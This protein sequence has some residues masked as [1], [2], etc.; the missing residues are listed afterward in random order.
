MKKRCLINSYVIAVILFSIF[1]NNH[2]TAQN[3]F[4]NYITITNGEFR[5]GESVFKPLFINYIVDIACYS[6]N[7]PNK[8]YFIA[9]HF[10]YSETIQCFEP[11]EINGE[12]YDCHFGFA[13]N[14]T[15][16]IDSIN[17]KLNH[18]LEVMD[19]L[20]FN[21]V[22]IAP[23]VRWKNHILQIPT[24]SYSK[25]FELMDTLIEKCAQHNLR[26]ILVLDADTD[27]FRQFDQYCV[28]LDS[29]SRHFSTN[30]TVMA[31][32]AY[33]E[34]GFKW[35]NHHEKD[36]IMISNWSRKWYYIIKKNA[37]NQLVTFGLDGLGNVL[38]WDPS[39]LTYDF[40][41]MHFYHASS[42]ADS[43]KMAVSCY[44]K[45]MNDNVQDV[46]VLGETGYSGTNSGDIC[47]QSLSSQTG[48]ERDQYHYA[49]HTMQ[50][51]LECGCKGYS[52]WQYQDV[53]WGNC[54]QNYLGLVTYYP[55]N[56]LKMAHSLFPTY[57]FR[58]VG[59][60]CD[61]PSRYYNIPG[62]SYN[63][64][65]GVVRDNH[66]NP[67]KDAVVF[68]WSRPSYKTQYTTFTDNQG[69]YT[70]MTPQDTIIGL[71]WISHK[72]YTSATVDLTR[73]AP[74]T[75][76]LTQINYN[77]WKKNWTNIYY[78]ETGDIPIIGGSDAVVV[79]NFCDDEA[80]EL[81][82]VK[83]SSNTAILYK[84]NTN[85]WE[86]MCS[87]AIGNWQISSGD[88]FYV[89]DFNGD[90]YDELLCVQNISNALAKIFRYN[91]QNLNYPWQ[92]LW[93]NSGNGNIG[94]WNYAPGDVILPGHFT[95][96]SFC[97][98]ICI[99]NSGRQ[100]GA[101]CQRL[102]S[103]SWTTLWT[104]TTGIG[105]TYIGPW[106]LD[107]H[108][109]YYVGDFSGDGIDELFCV[110]ATQGSSDKMTLMQYNSSWSSL[111]SN[112][113]ISQGVDIYPYR[114]NLH[115]GNY[116]PD[117]ADE[118][119]GVGTEAAKFDLNASNQW[120]KSWS[121]DGTGR[122]SDWSVNPNHRIFFMKTMSLVPD[123]LFV[124]RIVDNHYHCDG[125]S[126]DP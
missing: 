14:R 66:S 102:D 28:Y 6:P 83:S 95:S 67:I 27:A 12:N 51:A 104:A 94:N 58:T 78:P 65:Q 13:N 56:N 15:D 10:N 52:W 116:D 77:R 97:S 103:G 99:R 37:P 11:M 41:S 23:T 111:W 70:I 54:L 109:K 9:P 22:R 113:G 25:Y 21:V 47:T 110:Q 31:Y 43:S 39:A 36:K 71:V 60:P 48:T 98:L 26:V 114:A 32:V 2:L 81:L 79:G 108:D 17:L 82:I 34:P 50:K 91:P 76:H 96:T 42:D 105:G 40:L 63:N 73:T 107:D 124:S 112:N 16:E 62:C 69:N 74:Y 90:G 100:K 35:K 55:D 115:V 125:Y 30:K 20:G 75:T 18:D 123:Y 59:N 85:H 29:V 92:N 1:T 24:G 126:F 72:G 3:D 53:M 118:L 122:L 88:K 45:W 101:L 86:Q 64:I 84:Y 44:F 120:D 61:R 87:S 49:D 8:T 5:D 57:K 46:W 119:L 106:C 68:A 33:A 93:T 7:F 38:F 89:G 19:S 80:Q 117:L 4:T 121:T